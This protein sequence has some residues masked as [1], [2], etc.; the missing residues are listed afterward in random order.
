MS[1]VNPATV[2]VEQYVNHRHCTSPEQRAQMVKLHGPDC[3]TDN[4]YH[5]KVK[6]TVN[7][8]NP[9][10]G[11]FLKPAD[12]EKLIADGVKVNIVPISG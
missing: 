8:I 5:Y 1:K 6:S 7:T 12:V 2:T 11:K 10:L 3:D 9:T 4:E